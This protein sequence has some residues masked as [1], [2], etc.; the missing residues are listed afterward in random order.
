[1][2]IIKKIK[3]KIKRDKEENILNSR[4]Y[5]LIA[6]Q[7]QEKAEIGFTRLNAKLYI[8][9]KEL[10]INYKFNKKSDYCYYS[11]EIATELKSLIKY[12]YVEEKVNEIDSLKKYKKYKLTEKGK[13]MIELYREIIDPNEEE[14]VQKAQ[15]LN[16]SF[17]KH[18]NM[19]LFHRLSEE[20][21]EIR[22]MSKIRSQA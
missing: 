20:Y 17:S 11:E 13:I 5:I 16:N 21:P 12:N 9:N 8:I 2:K 4:V 14:K 1:M 3:K 10:G 18:K 6:L 7:D 15:K 19:K 22:K